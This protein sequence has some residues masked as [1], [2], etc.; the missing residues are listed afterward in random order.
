MS[1]AVCVCVCLCVCV[2]VCVSLGAQRPRNQR[3]WKIGDQVF[4]PP[5]PLTLSGCQCT[6]SLLNSQSLSLSLPPLHVCVSAY[7]CVS[8][9]VCICVWVC[10]YVCV[11]VS[12]GVC[13]CVCVCV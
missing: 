6:F 8:V 2:C 1:L 9:Y 4:V 7:M 5:P 11:Y 3:G 13:V 12:V 10:S